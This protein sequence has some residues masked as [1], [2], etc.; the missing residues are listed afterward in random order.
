[1]TIIE[2]AIIVMFLTIFS[3]LVY[4][5]Y[6]YNRKVVR[7]NDEFKSDI[8]RMLNAYKLEKKK[9]SFRKEYEI[10]NMPIITLKMY[11]NYYKFILDTGADFN[12]LD[13][14]A[15][16]RIVSENNLKLNKDDLKQG[17]DVVGGDT[18]VGVGG[19]QTGIKDV[20]LPF[21][22][23]DSE[24]EEIFSVVSIGAPLSAYEKH[25]IKLCGVIGSPFFEKN[26]WVLD[27]DELVVWTE[28]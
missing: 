9:I 3:I 23:D 21:E 22:C 4:G 24:F 20:Q 10:T 8:M 17:D 7:D 26:K 2:I 6:D 25:G 5:A 27:F 16:D 11:D 13:S 19:V 1:M 14:S 28:S 15:L 12:A 18:V